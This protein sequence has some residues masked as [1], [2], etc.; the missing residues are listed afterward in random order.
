MAANLPPELQKAWARVKQVSQRVWT[1]TRTAAQ[2]GWTATRVHSLRAWTAVKKAAG[3]GRTRTTQLWATASEHTRNGLKHGWISFRDSWTK[4]DW[5]AGIK[6]LPPG[7]AGNLTAIAIVT[8]L[9][10]TSLVYGD[11]HERRIAEARM[12]PSGE[13]PSQ[14][15]SAPTPEPVPVPEPVTPAEPEAAPAPSAGPKLPQMGEAFVDRFDGDQ[16]DS[17]WYVSD[18]WSNGDWMD[19]DWRASQ[20]TLGEHGATMT[21]EHGPEGHPKP[22]ASAEMKVHQD[23]RY[24]YFEIR[25]RVPRGPGIVTGVFTYAG[26][27]GKVRPHEIDIEILGRHT[28]MLEATIHEN[29]K[30]THKRIRL[31]FDA[32]D[33]FHTYG[34]DWQPDAIR[35]YADGKMIHEERGP[36]VARMT[37]PQ[38][39]IIDLWATKALKEWVGPLNMANAPWKLDIACT[40]YNPTYTGKPICG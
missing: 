18:G 38:Q 26:Q 5:M 37:R 36:V 24:G 9:V 12:I 29:G 35:W 2:R 33:G 11:Y 28:N 10:V 25:M 31:P 4:Q 1:D 19:N 7:M 32:A 30:P 23:F 40:A 20:I 22:L 39:F 21:M 14:Q 27:D 15:Q 16:L 6:P 34:F 3:E 8:G 17:R 13:H